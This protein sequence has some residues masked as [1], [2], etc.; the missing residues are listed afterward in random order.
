MATDG[1]GAEQR[2]QCARH[3]LKRHDVYLKHLFPVIWVARLHARETDRPAGVVDERVNRAKGL[4][5]VAQSIDFSLHSEVSDKDVGARL[6]SENLEVLAS[7]CD[8]DNV[9]AVL[10]K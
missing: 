5:V 2:Q 1:R 6:G 7:P 9:P 8:P 3:A 4:Q 10:A